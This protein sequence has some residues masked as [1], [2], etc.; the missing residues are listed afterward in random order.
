VSGC[1]APPAPNINALAAAVSA[2]RSLKCHP[3]HTLAIVEGDTVSAREARLC[4]TLQ[5]DAPL[6]ALRDTD[7]FVSYD[8]AGRALSIHRLWRESNQLTT[9]FETLRSQV[10]TALGQ[11]RECVL[12]GGVRIFEWKR[13]GVITAVWRGPSDSTIHWQVELA[14]G[15]DTC[16]LNS[17]G[18]R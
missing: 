2:N 6:P 1:A 7:V 8:S 15:V 14:T 13:D 4:S 11:G 18:H 16:A 3:P 9:R 10:G 12:D 5:P 17:R